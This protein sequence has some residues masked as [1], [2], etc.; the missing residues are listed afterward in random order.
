M[1]KKIKGVFSES[2][3]EEESTQERK[4]EGEKEQERDLYTLLSSGRSFLP[5]IMPA[6]LNPTQAKQLDVVFL[7]SIE[8]PRTGNITMEEITA[9]DLEGLKR[10][11]NRWR[12]ILDL[13]IPIAEV[14]TRWGFSL[15]VELELREGSKLFKAVT[16]KSKRGDRS[17]D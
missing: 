3:K 13:A 16:I 6:I 4:E 17:D 12:E 14:L 5:P 7:E 15:N 1:A 9:H 8:D 11:D 2:A 10:F